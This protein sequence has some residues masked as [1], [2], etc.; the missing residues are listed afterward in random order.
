MVSKRLTMLNYKGET[1]NLDG[2]KTLEYLEPV[3]GLSVTEGSR[4]NSTSI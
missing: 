4:L 3:P 2:L 1:L